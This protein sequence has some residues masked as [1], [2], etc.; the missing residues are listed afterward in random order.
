MAQLS[1]VIFDLDG[2]LVNTERLKAQSYARAAQT[3]S[4][5]PIDEQVF[6]DAFEDVVGRSRH[7]VGE[8][9]MRRF[10]LEAGAQR[11]MGEL[12]VASP[13]DAYLTIRL[14]IY[15]EIL[16]DPRIIPDNVFPHTLAVLRRA[17]E[18]G[19]ATGLATMS[20]REQ[21][22][23]ILETLGLFDAFDVIATREDVERGKP[24]P[25]IYI[26]VARHMNRPPEHCLVIED[27]VAGVE[28]GIAAGMTVVAVSTP[29][30]KERL[31]Q[32]DLLPPEQLIHDPLLLTGLV[33]HLVFDAGRHHDDHQSVPR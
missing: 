1:A 17:V 25:E 6:F 14:R 33:D 27:S 7:E 3:L 21:T 32:A 23:R 4:A 13:L 22:H 20:H 16:A 31:I 19:L 15:D 26:H 29:F 9:L 18:K 24:D 5:T 10:Q 30:T 28:A 11:A 2:T 12:G 8:A